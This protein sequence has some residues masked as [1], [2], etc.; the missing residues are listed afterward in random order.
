MFSE[1]THG[2][3]FEFANGWQVSM[4]TI[5]Q[6]EQ[7]RFVGVEVRRPNGSIAETGVFNTDDFTHLMKKVSEYEL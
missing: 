1:L 3:H 2:F 4:E 5:G 7:S 6:R